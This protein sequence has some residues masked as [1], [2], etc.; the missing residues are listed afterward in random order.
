[1]SEKGKMI[2]CF[3]M[4]LNVMV[5]KGRKMDKIELEESSKAFWNK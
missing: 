5:G 4:R 3:K 2:C 1:M